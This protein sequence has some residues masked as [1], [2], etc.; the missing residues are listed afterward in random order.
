M[1]AIIC[2]GRDYVPNIS[3][4]SNLLDRI[5]SRFNLTEVVHGAA[6][7]ADTFGDEWAKGRGIPR[8]PFRVT[9]E[10]W[11]MYGPSAGPRRNGDMLKHINNEGIVIAFPG[12]RG[13]SD[14][15]NRA[16]QHGLD[17]VFLN[18]GEIFWPP[19]TFMPIEGG[20]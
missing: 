7:G 5:H 8:T 9:K 11:V 12:G 17:C 18:G 4:D 2:G 14:M 13:T 6:T 19:H 20:E 1:K 3:V 10:D 15:V 16:Q